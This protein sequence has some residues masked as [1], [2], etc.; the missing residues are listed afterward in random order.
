MKLL[1]DTHILQCIIYML[2]QYEDS[3]LNASATD[4]RVLPQGVAWRVVRVV[5]VGGE[6]RFQEFD[7]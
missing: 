7:H 5:R 6:L 3:Y 4:R 1:F 2:L